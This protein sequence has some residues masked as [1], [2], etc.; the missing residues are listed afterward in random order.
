[1]Y[2]VEFEGQYYDPSYGT[3]STN[4]IESWEENTF[5]GYGLGIIDLPFSISTTPYIMTPQYI[6]WIDSIED[7]DNQDVTI[8]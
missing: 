2:I 3:P 1:L 6:H 4:S 7:N 5:Q 8:D